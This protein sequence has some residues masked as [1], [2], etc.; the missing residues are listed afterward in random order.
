MSRPSRVVGTLDR[1]RPPLVDP[2]DGD[3]ESDES[4]PERRS[5]LALA[6]NLLTEVSPPK[7]AVALL[8]LIVVP[9]VVLGLVS[10]VATMWWSTLQ[11]TKRTEGTGALVIL[12]ALVAG[13]WFGGRRLWRVVERSFWALNAMAI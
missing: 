12:A 10:P 2:R 7:L 3:I 8:L 11:S 13:A 6:G 9:A 1:R 5:L 4:S